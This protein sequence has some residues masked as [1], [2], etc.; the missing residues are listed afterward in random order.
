MIKSPALAKFAAA[1]RQY[2]AHTHACGREYDFWPK[3]GEAERGTLTWWCSHCPRTL[4]LAITRDEALQPRGSPA[5][6]DELR[7]WTDE[8]QRLILD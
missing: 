4:T 8:L 1:F 5:D 6:D 2:D 3:S 7:I